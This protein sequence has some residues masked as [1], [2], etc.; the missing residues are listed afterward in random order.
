M[1]EIVHNS[2]QNL[3]PSKDIEI[4]TQG[5]HGKGGQHQNKTDSAVRMK[6]IP[7]GISVF[8]NG[9]KQSQNKKIAYD[10]LCQKLKEKLKTEQKTK[11]RKSKSKQFDGLGRSGN[12][13]RTY[14]LINS[15]I[16]DH[17]TNVKTSNISAILDSG[18]LDMLK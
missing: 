15:R 16:T 14:N 9:R 6:H 17:I 7:T 18:Q 8:V 11:F 3:I 12:K 4:K 2:N 10:L 1:T 13:I 5:G